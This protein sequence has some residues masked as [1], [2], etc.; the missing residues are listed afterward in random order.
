MFSK[1]KS[2]KVEAVWERLT[3]LDRVTGVAEHHKST[4]GLIF[5]SIGLS[6]GVWVRD[7]GHPDS[8][9]HSGH[10]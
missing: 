10:S 7:E 2:S 6:D 9:Y 4:I 8:S 1:S 3:G 5:V